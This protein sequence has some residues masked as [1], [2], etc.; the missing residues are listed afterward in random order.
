[1]H[2]SPHDI[3]KT[4]FAALLAEYPALIASVS[5][6]KPPRPGKQSLAQ[7]DAFRYRDA[8]DVVAR[9]DDL[10]KS[11]VARLVDWKLRHGKYRPSLAALVAS[12][13]PSVMQSTISAALHT[14]R[15]ALATPS[16]R[17]DA[18]KALCVLRGV[19][20]ATASLLLAVHDPARVA[21]FSDEAFA[22]LCA[23]E[24]SSSSSSSSWPKYSAAEYAS[25]AHAVDCL[26]ARLGVDAV[27]VEKVAYVILRSPLPP[28]HDSHQT[29][30]DSRAKASAPSSKPKRKSPPPSE[31]NHTGL[32]RS[33]RLKA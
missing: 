12:N 32:R 17:R 3:S 14:Y 15:A 8:L 1:M 19:G 18:I 13:S 30:S 29:K 21:F 20:P 11:H 33:K 10:T 5:A 25:L 28:V 26:V 22:W 23:G 27:D 16:A 24:G 2:P 4:Q 6:S 7:L 9:G 31:P